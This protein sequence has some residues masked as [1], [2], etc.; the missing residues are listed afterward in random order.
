[1][2][3]DETTQTRAIERAIV[4][5]NLQEISRDLFA[6]INTTLDDKLTS[7]SV[8][9]IYCSKTGQPIGELSAQ[10]LSD[11]LKNLGQAALTEL[12]YAGNANAVHPAWI[13]TASNEQYNETL[14]KLCEQFPQAYAAYCLGRITQPN[15]RTND[16]ATLW[17]NFQWSLRRAY[18]YLGAVPELKLRELCDSL[19][20]FVAHMPLRA[21]QELIG[22]RANHADILARNAIAGILTENLETALSNHYES[23]IEF[24]IAENRPLSQTNISAQDLLRGPSHVRATRHAR[25]HIIMRKF[26]E[27]AKPAE[28]RTKAEQFLGDFATDFVASLGKAIPGQEPWRKRFNAGARDETIQFRDVP[29]EI[30]LADLGNISFAEISE[31]AGMFGNAGDNVAE[32]RTISWE[33]LRSRGRETIEQA[34][35]K[36]KKALEELPVVSRVSRFARQDLPVA[37]TQSTNQSTFL[38]RFKRT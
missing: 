16:N 18:Q 27:T 7:L 12:L 5:Q 6:R 30:T 2:I 1:M 31:P 20:A 4:A 38:S 24:S 32:M 11:T 28:K 10:I 15:K 13:K 23:N 34:K 33:E 29:H 35:I 3:T 14:D 8:T 9:A 17:A 22:D 21:L 26:K 25:Q 37:E 19:S 36:G